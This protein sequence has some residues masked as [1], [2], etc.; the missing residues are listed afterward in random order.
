[1]LTAID[2][3]VTVDFEVAGA[4]F[5]L[6]TVP[7]SVW[8]RAKFRQILAY[9]S[10]QR[11]A[12]ARMTK[13]G[14]P[15]D[16]LMTIGGKQTAVPRR[17]F[18]AQNDPEL[19]AELTL[20]MCDLLRYG[21][22]GHEGIVLPDARALPFVTVDERIEGTLMKVVAPETMRVYMANFGVMEQVYGA[23]YKRCDLSDSAKK[24]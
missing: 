1:M 6:G 22:R 2:P 10:A 20:V 21:V 12:V 13:D 17:E 5:K 3:D 7:A 8:Q 4:V 24:V 23:L 11:R 18:L 9:E 19:R 16:D 15:P 14:L